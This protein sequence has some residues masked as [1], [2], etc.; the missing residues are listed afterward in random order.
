MCQFWGCRKDLEIVLTLKELRLGWRWEDG[1]HG[2]ASQPVAQDYTD[3]GAEP[4]LGKAE[5]TSSTGR[6]SCR[7]LSVLPLPRCE[8]G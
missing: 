8:R 1:A 3:R 4:S 5:V 7:N 6:G 2:Q